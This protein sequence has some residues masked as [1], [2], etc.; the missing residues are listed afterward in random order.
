MSISSLASRQNP[1]GGWPYVRGVSWTEPTVYA[2]MALLAARETD[3][4][5]RGLDWLAARQRRD[6]GWPPQ[7]AVDQSTWVTG[8]VALLPVSEAVSS[9]AHAAAIRWLMGTIGHESTVE[10]R[11]REWLLGDAVP[12]DQEFAGWPWIPG[13][14]AWVGPTSIALLAL[15]KENRRRPSTAIEDRIATGRKYL[16]SRMCQGGGWNH[17]S[18]RALGYDSDPYPETTGMAL[19]ALRGDDSPPIGQALRV[20]RRF[21]SQCHSADALNW[22][23]I[24]LQAHGGV[25]AGFVCPSGVARRTVPEQA[26]S[27]LLDSPEAPRPFFWE[28]V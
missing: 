10:Y 24:G 1:D 16:L 3:A 22:L 20:A 14:A 7:A 17:G 27:L 6:G 15:G 25:P 21:L 2:V 23:R 18:A 4:A 28:A 8:L 11:V 12:S 13:A 5:R 9:A 19:A 26:L